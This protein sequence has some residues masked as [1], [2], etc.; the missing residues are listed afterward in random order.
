MA[1][2]PSKIN[3]RREFDRGD[4]S[5][6]KLYLCASSCIAVLLA[7]GMVLSVAIVAPGIFGTVRITG[8]ISQLNWARGSIGIGQGVECERS[9]HWRRCSR[10]TA[11]CDEQRDPH[12]LDWSYADR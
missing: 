10:I 4:L 12:T 2:L 5:P 11:T 6:L 8:T 9:T 1:P 7:G 3:R